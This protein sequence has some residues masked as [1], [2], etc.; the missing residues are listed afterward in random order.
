MSAATARSAGAAGI[1][2]IDGPAG[3]GKSTVARMAAARLG[4]TVLDTGAMY[5][6]VTLACLEAGADLEDEAACAAIAASIEIEQDGP[7]TRVN[8]T[9]VSNEIRTPH[10]NASV[11]AVSAHPEVRRIMVDHQR[12]WAATHSGGVV[13]GRDI[14]TV[15]F[16]DARLKV[17]L[18]AS[19]DERAR[20]R[21]ADE[22]AAGRAVDFADV[23]AAIERRDRIDS[24]RAASPLRAA[25]DAWRIDS[26]DRAI[27]DVVDEIVTRYKEVTA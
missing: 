20:R 17:F 16:P 25:T 26:T 23:R 3:A 10:V 6:A 18:S 14:G 1:L 19:D 4:L 22:A 12:A 2:A 27:D 9:D 21:M 11:S 8:G 24:H 5:R 15:V 7:C 13:E